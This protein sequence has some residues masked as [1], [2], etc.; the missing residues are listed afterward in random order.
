MKR[1]ILLATAV[2]MSA[3]LLAANYG[4]SLSAKCVGADNC[5]A[6]ENCKYCKYCKK[7]GGTCGVC[8]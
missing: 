6:C 3:M 4:S 7:D 2:A 5:K 1:T 8:K